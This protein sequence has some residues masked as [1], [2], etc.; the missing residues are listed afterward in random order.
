M[1]KK[2][3]FAND[4]KTRKVTYD[5]LCHYHSLDGKILTVF[6]NVPNHFNLQFFRK[7][8]SRQKKKKHA[9]GKKTFPAS[10][11]ILHNVF[12]LQVFSQNIC[13][14]AYTIFLRIFLPLHVP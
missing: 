9:L 6:K 3:D 7:S 14:P 4:E 10:S 13:I 1:L 11:S 8:F 12:A 2:D 5:N